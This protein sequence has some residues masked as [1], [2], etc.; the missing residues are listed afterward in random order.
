MLS[1]AAA[2]ATSRMLG[3]QLRWGRR[4]AW[5]EVVILVRNDT[6]LRRHRVDRSGDPDRRSGT[7]LWHR[8]WARTQSSRPSCAACNKKKDGVEPHAVQTV[9]VQWLAGDVQARI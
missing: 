1:T 6:M 8:V 4:A 7:M 3:M 5:I 2:A 9:L